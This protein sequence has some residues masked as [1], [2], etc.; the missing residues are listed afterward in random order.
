[1]LVRSFFF[2]GRG[3]FFLALF[4][5]HHFSLSLFPF[6]YL[7]CPAIA[8]VTY[9]YQ[10]KVAAGQNPEDEEDPEQAAFMEEAMGE[11]DMWGAADEFTSS[12]DN[13]NH[14]RFFV[15]TLGVLQQMGMAQAVQQG[16]SPAL[17]ALMQRLVQTCARQDEA[18]NSGKI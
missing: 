8:I 2:A 18:Y 13:E 16:L 6:P 14:L 9:N 11:Y 12:V 7:L 5:S 15:D 3:G 10:A 1:M 17:S 4:L